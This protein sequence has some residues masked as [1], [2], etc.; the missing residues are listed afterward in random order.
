MYSGK[1]G[2]RRR[3][4]DWEDSTLWLSSRVQFRTQI[5]FRGG[6]KYGTEMIGKQVSFV[7]GPRV[8]RMTKWGE[9][10]CDRKR[11]LVE[12]QKEGSWNSPNE[13]PSRCLVSSLPME[14][15]KGLAIREPVKHP[16]IIPLFSDCPQ[17]LKTEDGA[18][19]PTTEI[20]N[21]LDNAEEFIL[22]VTSLVFSVE[23]PKA[24]KCVGD[25]LPDPTNP[26]N[27]RRARL[28][29]LPDPSNEF[30][31]R[32]SR[33]VPEQ[34][35]N[36]CFKSPAAAVTCVSLRISWNASHSNFVARVKKPSISGIPVVNGA[37]LRANPSSIRRRVYPPHNLIGGWKKCRNSKYGMDIGRVA[38]SKKTNWLERHRRR[39][40]DEILSRVL[41]DSVMFQRREDTM[42]KERELET[43]R[44]TAETIIE[45]EMEAM[46]FAEKEA[47]KGRQPAL[48]DPTGY[49]S[50]VR[51]LGALSTHPQLQLQQNQKR[52]RVRSAYMAFEER[53]LAKLG[54]QYPLLSFSQLKRLVRKDW[55]SSPQNPVNRKERDETEN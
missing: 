48:T 30:V 19:A 22:D 53:R 23:L 32:C 20:G 47:E 37:S 31:E 7:R 55:L 45:E 42:P 39:R 16:G 14:S 40:I 43:Q 11:R 24:V 35:Q 52:F 8:V 29:Y 13:G 17:P 27:R 44:S 3:A 50:V 2:I 49:R 10:G 46:K 41:P 28:V 4:L 25:A 1:P 9:A 18:Q 12:C 6:L 54:S 33:S 51:Q 38:M 15:E 5:V 26:N 21:I 34:F 36:V